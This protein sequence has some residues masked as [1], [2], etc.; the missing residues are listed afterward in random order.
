[1]HREPSIAVVTRLAT[2]TLG[3]F[4][5][6]AA[7]E[8]GV[9]RKQL[10]TLAAHG[11]IERVLRDTYRLTGSA[12]SHEQSL[13][14]AILWTDCIGVGRARSAAMVYGLEGV[15][16]PQPQIVVPS[17][18]RLTSVPALHTHLDRFGQRGRSGV[19][20]MRRVLL[21][22]DPNTRHAR[23]SRSRRADCS[24]STGSATS[25]ASSH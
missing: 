17:T 20:S 22:L 10:G 13:H 4:R 6:R 1:M 8:L 15:R 16:T 7:V 14:A 9:S 25:S 21:Q 24:W 5:G 19:T 23:H 12:R 11:A 3:A 18:L 2:A